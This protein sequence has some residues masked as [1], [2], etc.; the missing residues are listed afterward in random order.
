MSVVTEPLAVTILFLLF[1]VNLTQLLQYFW[2]TYDNLFFNCRYKCNIYMS[3]HGH[4]TV[5]SCLL[6]LLRRSLLKK[7]KIT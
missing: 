1:M 2:Q 7:E 3:A 5:I 6:F 4:S